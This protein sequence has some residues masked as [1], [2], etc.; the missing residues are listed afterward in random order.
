MS[1]YQRLSFLN[2]VN[3]VR[4]I[5]HRGS[6]LYKGH[7]G[8]KDIHTV[9]NKH[10]CTKIKPRTNSVNHWVLDQSNMH[11]LETETSFWA[12]HWAFL[13]CSVNSVYLI[14]GSGVVTVSQGHMLII[15]VL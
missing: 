5:P 1:K 4:S 13:C 15:S 7:C 11:T 9:D 3:V 2:L 14:Q 12:E 6:P 10:K 8:V